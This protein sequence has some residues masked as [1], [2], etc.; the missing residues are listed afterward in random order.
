MPHKNTPPDIPRLEQQISEERRRFRERLG[1][2]DEVTSPNDPRGR[3]HRVF[4][5]AFGE[6][7]S[8]KEPHLR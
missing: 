3:L 8:G 5:A 1:L 7:I 4:L 6:G 2:S